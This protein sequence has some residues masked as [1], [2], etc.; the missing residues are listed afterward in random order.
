MQ[1]FFKLK[2][3]KNNMKYTNPQSVFNLH[4]FEKGPSSRIHSFLPYMNR[5]Y[6][7][8]VQSGSKDLYKNYSLR[9]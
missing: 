5:N 3:I 7:K 1:I 8:I 9:L 4:H 6:Q 2:T